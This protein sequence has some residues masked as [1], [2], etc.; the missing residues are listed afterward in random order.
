MYELLT[1]LIKHTAEG[2][3]DARA[4][5][6]VS[7]YKYQAHRHGDD[8]NRFVADVV[9]RTYRVSHRAHPHHHI[10]CNSVPK[11]CTDHKTS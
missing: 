7:L 1:V 11:S 9:F 6:N 5:K 10:L 8:T 2:W 3:V 4:L